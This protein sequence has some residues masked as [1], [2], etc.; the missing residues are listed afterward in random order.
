MSKQSWIND[1]L[2]QWKLIDLEGFC[3][4]LN[5][6]YEDVFLQP[7]KNSVVERN[8][9]DGLVFEWL[10]HSQAPEGL[11]HLYPIV[12]PKSKITW[13]EWFIKPDGL[14]HHV[15]RNYEHP[16]ATN[17]WM[18]DDV[19]HPQQVCNIP[20]YYINDPDLRPVVLR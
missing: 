2:D 16:E 7:I 1:V 18:G 20:W 15:L 8:P 10:P 11:I 14:H 9:F 6:N 13:E 4:K 3:E 19:D 12:R 5:I 17:T